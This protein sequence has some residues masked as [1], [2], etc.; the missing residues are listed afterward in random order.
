MNK[1][2]LL[3]LAKNCGF[4][5]VAIISAADF[6]FNLDFR[7]YCEENVCSRY[8][9]NYSCPPACGEAVDMM[10]KV[11]SYKN[12]L[13]LQSKHNIPNLTDNVALSKAKST[14]NK[15]SL[16]VLNAFLKE[17]INCLMMGA[18][19]CDL[20]TPC[21]ITAGESCSFPSIAYSCMSAYCIDVKALAEKCK[22]DYY[23]DGNVL[24]LFGAII[25]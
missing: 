1:E 20:C 13:I 9:A 19:Y 25:F 11:L 7:K 8:M 17:N 14:H 2:K 23:Y 12:A 10:E 16:T 18:G 21:K 5:A 4:A 22:M 3:N 15:N 24:P 6:K